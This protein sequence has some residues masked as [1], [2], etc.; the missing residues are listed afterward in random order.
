[1]G[2]LAHLASWDLPVCCVCFPTIKKNSRQ[3]NKITLLYVLCKKETVC[4][5]M[6]ARTTTFFSCVWMILG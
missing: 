1:M 5:I 6:C 2:T 4:L 3:D